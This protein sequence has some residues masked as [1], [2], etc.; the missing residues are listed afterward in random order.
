MTRL[1]P[2]AAVALALTCASCASDDSGAP[3]PAQANDEA[4]PTDAFDVPYEFTA[5][6]GSIVGEVTA[7]VLGN[8]GR[9]HVVYE[10]MLTNAKPVEAVVERIDVVD[11]ADTERVLASFDQEA[12]VAEGRDLA[13][14]ARLDGESP[15][16]TDDDV[17]LTP[18][19][20]M[21]VLL[22][23]QFDSLDDVPEQIVHRFVGTAA[24]SPA[25]V[26]DA[27]DYLFVPWQLRTREPVQIA[28]PLS[29]DGWVVVNGCCGTTGAHR[30]SVQTLAGELWD[31]QRFAID[32]IKIGENGSFAD[33]DIGVNENWYN[34][35]EPVHAVADGVVVSV[36]DGLPDQDPGQLPDPSGI[37]IETV[38]GNHVV[39]RLAD[40]V[41]AF[42]AHISPGTVSVEAGDEV[43]AG[44]VI[45]RLGNSGNTSGPHLHF[46]LMTTERPL[47]AD[48]IPFVIDGATTTGSL[49]RT[50]WDAADV[51][52][53]VW[54][55]AEPASP[56]PDGPFLPLDLTVVSLS[57]AEDG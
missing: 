12:L 28:P 8:D 55:I 22:Q 48:S 16:L 39:L 34:Y 36:L 54:T 45:G 30:G 26:A 13:G 38:D 51:L 15:T 25:P 31:A 1:L 9:Y 27:V 53:P 50:E 40:G 3:E 29:G 18:N 47:A 6:V 37:T 5:V 4:S 32:W 2:A 44:D 17:V 46:H 19:E 33:G 7:P 56:D 20:S 49:D 57:L 10:M 42:Y 11:A 23:L 21:V 41:F 43:E 35:G 14:G 52:D 24:V